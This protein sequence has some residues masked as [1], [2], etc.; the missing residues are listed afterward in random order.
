MAIAPLEETARTE[1]PSGTGLRLVR[2]GRSAGAPARGAG[3]H[4]RAERAELEER[5]LTEQRSRADHPTARVARADR[6]SARLGTSPD[7]AE[8]S[9]L[10]RQVA[11]RAQTLARRRRTAAVGV[12]L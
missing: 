11:A 6:T 7:L 9:R 2:G 12:V 3:R 10:D 5:E 4:V 8:E 1:D